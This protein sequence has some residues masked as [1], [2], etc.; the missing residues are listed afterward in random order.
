MEAIG[1]VT[2]TGFRG[3]EAVSGVKSGTSNQSR[4]TAQRME[5]TVNETSSALI[6]E[7]QRST[8]D[9]IERVAQAMDEYV[10]SN[11][12]GLSI[13]VNQGTGD[14]MVRV[15][16]KEDGRTIREIPSRELLNLAARMEEMIGVLFNENV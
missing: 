10:K 14:I 16:A 9:K 12:R 8:R 7:A 4:R 13:Q 15:I 1:T 2:N 11:A 6:R 3:T 5:P